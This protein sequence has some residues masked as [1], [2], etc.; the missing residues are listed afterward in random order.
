[1][2][3]RV[4]LK[5]LTTITSGRPQP[6]GIIKNE[7]KNENYVKYNFPWN[8]PSIKRKITFLDDFLPRNWCSFNNTQLWICILLIRINSFNVFIKIQ[9]MF[10]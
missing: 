7:E 6:I 8:S 1:M 4:C 10:Y 2:Q 9:P 3:Q 5:E